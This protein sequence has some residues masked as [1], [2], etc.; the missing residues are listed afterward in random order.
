MKKTWAQEFYDRNK[1]DYLFQFEQYKLSVF[2]ALRERLFVSGLSTQELATR[3]GVTER[4]VINLLKKEPDIKLS[5]LV[6]IAG[7]LGTH[8]SEPELEEIQ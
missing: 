2:S 7:A 5:M 8:W 6:K 3:I 4:R 1:G